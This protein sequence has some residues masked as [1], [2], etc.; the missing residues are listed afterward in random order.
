MIRK[1]INDRFYNHEAILPYKKNPEVV[2]NELKPILREQKPSIKKAVKNS[3]EEDDLF[4]EMEPN[5]VAARRIG[6]TMLATEKKNK[7]TSRFD[8]DAGC[9]NSWEVEDLN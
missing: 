7:A 9:E 3:D 6:A 5:Y 1:M 8:M 4:K 2:S